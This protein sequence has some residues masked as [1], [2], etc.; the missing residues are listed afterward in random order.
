MIFA[1]TFKLFQINA[2]Q[3][4]FVLG[5]FSFSLSILEN[6]PALGLWLQENYSEF[7]RFLLKT[8]ENYKDPDLIKNF[9]NLQAKILLYYELIF[10]N[11]LE[12]NEII[13][14]LLESLLNISEY[15]INREILLFFNSFVGVSMVYTSLFVNIFLRLSP[16]W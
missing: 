10:F 3:N 15:A 8:F 2:K 9:T 7:N 1:T 11:S 16:V 6:D 13:A 5:V 14:V 12:Y 4:S